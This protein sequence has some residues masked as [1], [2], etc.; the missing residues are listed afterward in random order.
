[1][2][3]P[4][5]PPVF[6]SQQRPAGSPDVA[7]APPLGVD[8]ELGGL[9]LG[10]LDQLS[11]AV[12]VPEAGLHDTLVAILTGAVDLLDG[13]E[14]AGVNLFVKGQFSPQAV[15]G[16]APPVLDELQ[17]RTGSGPCIDASREQRT[18]EIADTRTERRWPEFTAL[19]VSLGVWSM[20]CVPLWIDDRRLGS[21][22]LY[23]S[24]PNGRSATMTGIAGL[25]ATH[26]ALALGDAQRTEN[27]R[28]ALDNRD[29]IGQAKGILM[30]TRGLLADD[31]F[32]VLV[33]TSQQLNRKL[34]DVAAELT[35][36]GALPT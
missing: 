2:P 26:A 18:I 21:L 13:V 36:T 27:L 24:V 8:D 11:R 20:L 3:F 10:A 23:G 33:T 12:H 9:S 16:D 15:R 6:P 25:Y 35:V 14:G 22:S 1:L 5:S 17:Q 34:V 7:E 28:R 19:A 29:V 31:A 4:D 30:A 32:A